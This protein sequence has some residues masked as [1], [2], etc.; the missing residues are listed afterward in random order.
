[1][2]IP[3]V[4]KTHRLALYWLIAMGVLLWTCCI[5]SEQLFLGTALDGCFWQLKIQGSHFRC[6]NP[7]GCLNVLRG[8]KIVSSLL[9]QSCYSLMSVKGN[10]DRNKCRKRRFC[11]NGHFIRGST[12]TGFRGYFDVNSEE[13]TRDAALF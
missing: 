13:S 3:K 12:E 5:F 4:D 11:R 7:N 10:L 8:I 6:K 9:L 2:L 1:M